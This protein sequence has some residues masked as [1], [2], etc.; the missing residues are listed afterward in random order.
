MKS[1]RQ[2]LVEKA[3]ALNWAFSDFEIALDGLELSSECPSDT[4]VS[5][6]EDAL[7]MVSNGI[8]AIDNGLVEMEKSK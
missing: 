8:T 6:L 1:D 5:Y 4:L 7:S 2:Q 3:V